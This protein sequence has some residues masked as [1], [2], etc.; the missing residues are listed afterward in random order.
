MPRVC[1]SR[2][3]SASSFFRIYI[4][5]DISLYKVPSEAAVLIT[6]GNS[7]KSKGSLMDDLRIDQLHPVTLH[8]A[9]E[10]QVKNI[11]LPNR[12]ARTLAY[13]H[14]RTRPRRRLLSFRMLNKS[15]ENTN[16]EP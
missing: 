2:T 8:L 13:R 3:V 10:N 6:R 15:F 11:I 16:G 7:V 5:A 12:M 1:L 14:I 4:F 9:R